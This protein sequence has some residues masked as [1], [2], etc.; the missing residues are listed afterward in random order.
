M[1][2]ETSSIDDLLLTQN[3]PS[4]PKTSENMGN[5]DASE[6]VGNS[7][8]LEQSA[9]DYGN[10]APE[11]SAE[12]PEAP[13]PQDDYGN[14][15]AAA[16]V[17]TEDEVNE[18][19][20]QAVRDRLARLERNSAQQPPAPAQ[21][22]Q[23]AQQGFEYNAESAE[24]WQQQ[25]ESFVEQTVGRMNQKQAQQAQQMREQQ[26]QAEFEQKFHQGMGKFKDYVDVVSTQPITDAMTVSLRSVKDP[27]AFLYAACK[28]EPKEIER[29]SRIQDPYAQIAEMG[30]LEERMKKARAHTQTPKPVARTHEDAAFS[31]K[32]DKEP[33]IEEL[34]HRAEAKKRAQINARKK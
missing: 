5:A 9:D 19:I 25:L 22:Q 14:E 32:S 6:P 30:K 13:A 28:R 21:V 1:T 17:Y 16:K 12:Q 34:I 18:R 7:E 10:E 24:S 27:A 2:H 23:A 33:T 31:S 8:Q 15:V 4:T 20:N 3:A 29:I 11:A 26:A